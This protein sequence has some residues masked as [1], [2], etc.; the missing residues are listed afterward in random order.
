LVGTASALDLVLSGL[1]L[2]AAVHGSMPSIF[3]SLHAVS[4]PVVNFDVGIISRPLMASILSHFVGS[5]YAVSITD[6]LLAGAV[7][8]GFLFRLTPMSFAL[9]VTNSP[10]G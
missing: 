4:H 6:E 3:A 2:P 7:D 1:E 9:R 10:S 5:M 8:P